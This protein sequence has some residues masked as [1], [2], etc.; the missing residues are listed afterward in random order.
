MGTVGRHD[1]PPQRPSRPPRS[2]LVRLLPTSAALGAALTPPR[3]NKLDKQGTEIAGYSTGIVG[4]CGGFVFGGITGSVLSGVFGNGSTS[5][6][7][8]GAILGAVSAGL[9][10]F[11]IAAG[12]STIP[13]GYICSACE[14][15]WPK[16]PDT[17]PG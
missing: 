12:A 7:W 14:H 16:T 13:P 15:R 11:L 8:A 10:P 1:R 9:V 5:W 3:D 17:S 4:G 2:A 6:V